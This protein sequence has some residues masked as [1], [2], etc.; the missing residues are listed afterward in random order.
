[1]LRLHERPRLVGR[2]RN[3]AEPRTQPGHL[4]GHWTGHCRHDRQRQ[5]RARRPVADEEEYDTPHRIGE[6]DGK[7]EADPGN[8]AES[9]EHGE[10]PEIDGSGWHSARVEAP[11]QYSE[12]D[13]EQKGEDAPGLL[14]DEDVNAPADQILEAARLDP[15]L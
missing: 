7:A 8:H 13:T 12:A 14:L 5:E 3:T 10:T 15:H 11:E 4:S 1:M 2:L 6:E 9:G